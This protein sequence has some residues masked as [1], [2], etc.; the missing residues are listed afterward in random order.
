MALVDVDYKF[1]WVKVGA[2][3]ASSDTQIFNNSELK[4]AIEDGAIDFP[5]PDPLPTD[6]RHM[7]YF[8]LCDNAFALRTWLMKPCSKRNMTEDERI[9][10]YRISRGLRVMENAF[11]I[12]AN[13]FQCLLTT[14]RQQPKTVESIV[15]ACVCLHNIM[16]IRYPGLQNAALDQEDNEH[17]LIPGA[18][19]QGRNMA[20]VDNV[21]CGNRLTRAAKA[22]R[23]YLKHYFN[24]E[25]VAVPWQNAMI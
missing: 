13:K 7:P 25:A 9:F 10:N 11:G 12:M 16:R 2:N 15:L 6:D 3:G 1:I 14:L 22:Q 19:R 5:L 20:D 21:V 17:R 18:W 24:S 4:A 23:E 8:I